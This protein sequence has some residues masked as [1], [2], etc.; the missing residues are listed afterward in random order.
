MKKAF[1]SA[2]LLLGALLAN[3]QTARVLAERVSGDGS[4]WSDRVSE[5]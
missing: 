5:R 1:L 3:A 4:E 2:M